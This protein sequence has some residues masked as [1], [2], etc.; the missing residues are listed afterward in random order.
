MGMSLV[1]KAFRFY[2]LYAKLCLAEEPVKDPIQQTL[3][4]GT[5]VRFCKW[6]VWICVS[7]R[8]DR[9]NSSPATSGDG[10][11]TFLEGCN[12]HERMQEKVVLGSGTES[13][14]AWSIL[15]WSNSGMHCFK[16]LVNCG[17][18]FADLR[19]CWKGEEW[20]AEKLGEMYLTC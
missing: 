20:K 10:T 16:I 11:N 5:S 19:P 13:H 1:V 17:Q 2:E 12:I 6:E 9:V 18:S 15:A 4:L 3:Q 8:K 14:N 7:F